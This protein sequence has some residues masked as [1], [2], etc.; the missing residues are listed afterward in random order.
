MGY[1]KNISESHRSGI[2]CASHSK[3]NTGAIVENEAFD[4]RVTSERAIMLRMA[5]DLF[6]IGF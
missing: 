3:G 2:L 4:T 6:V 1:A 5:Y